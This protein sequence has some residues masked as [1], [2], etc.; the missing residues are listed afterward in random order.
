MTQRGNNVILR[1]NREIVHVTEGQKKRTGMQSFLSWEIPL[2]CGFDR[3][4][5]SAIV[6]IT[7]KPASNKA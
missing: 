4:R 1:T 5:R 6:P 3:L 2:Q 7:P